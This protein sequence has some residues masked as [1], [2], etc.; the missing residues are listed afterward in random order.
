MRRVLVGIPTYFGNQLVTNCAASLLKTMAKADIYILKNDDGWL[1]AANYLMEKAQATE[2]DLLLLNDDTYALGDLVKELQAVAYSDPKIGIVG[3][4]ALAPN[5]DTI[6]NYG[7]YVATDGNTAHR[8]YGKPKSEIIEVEKQKAI[9]GSCF[10]IKYEVMKT[11]GVFDEGYGNGYREEVDYCFRAREAGY[12]VVS[13]PKAEYVHFVNQTHGKLN[14][15]NDTYDY[16]MSKWG[17]KLKLG[18]V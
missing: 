9:E 18:V 15:H 6:I 3:G 2:M 11:I 1:K 12:D 17:S 4:K 7:I 13:A 10:Y 16:F 5:Q 14:I 8:Y